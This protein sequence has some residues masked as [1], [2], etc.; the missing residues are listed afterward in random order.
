[1]DK[2]KALELANYLESKKG[3]VEKVVP[4]HLRVDEALKMALIAV[5][6][7]SRL[8]SCSNTSIYRSLV[9]T[10]QMGL[11]LSP[12]LNEA[13]LIPYG[14][15]CTLQVGYRGW[16]KLARE[17]GELQDIYAETVCEN[18]KFQ[19]KKGLHPDLVHEIAVGGKAVRGVPTYVYAVA[20]FKS[21]YARFEV[22]PWSDIEKAKQL[23]KRGNK[24]N[25]AWA[26]WEEEMG[27]KVAIKRLVKT[28]PLGEKLARAAAIEHKAMD[29]DFSDPHVD[30]VEEYIDAKVELDEQ[31]IPAPHQTLKERLAHDLDG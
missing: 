31:P 11:S 14:D 13:H 30:Q 22:V 29:G 15:D 9:Q 23:S 26:M 6:D 16:L 18:D 17:S 24:V 28:L 8:L 7:N 20:L 1:M 27:K 4:P 5:T 2:S 12:V 19:V 25:P 10:C 3:E 21:G